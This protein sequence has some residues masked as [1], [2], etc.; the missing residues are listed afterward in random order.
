MKT[1]LRN[2]ICLLIVSTYLTTQAQTSKLDFA[3]PNE[4]FYQTQKRLT[5]YFKKHQR[6]LDEERREKAEGHLKVGAEED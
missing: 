6:Q 2:I 5:K 1:F 4:N 3:N